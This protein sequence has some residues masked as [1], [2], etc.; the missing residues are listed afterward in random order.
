MNHK[1]N[2]YTFFISLNIQQGSTK[3]EA[4]QKWHVLNEEEKK[5]Y[6]DFAQEAN[7]QNV[8]GKEKEEVKKEITEDGQK[9]DG[10]NSI[11]GVF[12]LRVFYC[13]RTVRAKNEGRDLDEINFIKGSYLHFW[14]GQFSDR[15][16]RGQI[17]SLYRV[18]TESKEDKRKKVKEIGE[19]KSEEVKNRREGLIDELPFIVDLSSISLTFCKVNQMI[20]Y[21]II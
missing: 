7:K 6:R 13:P 14:C 17:F 8:I 1:Y 21:V 3:E 12:R 5:K 11:R 19:I 9:N 18:F 20:H 15:T 4:Q 2:S 16:V 10:K